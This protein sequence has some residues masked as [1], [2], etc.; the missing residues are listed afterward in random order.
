MLYARGRR[1]SPLVMTCIART[2]LVSEPTMLSD[3]D[4]L[5]KAPGL[6]HYSGLRAIPLGATVVSMHVLTQPTLPSSASA[7]D[8]QAC[9]TTLR[10]VLRQLRKQGPQPI[11]GLNR[12]NCLC[13][14]MLRRNGI[15]AKA[16]QSDSDVHAA[17]SQV[18]PALPALDGK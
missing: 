10:P 17:Q 18:L 7:I 15:A 5:R 11:F 9:P 16:A 3:A 4:P 8:C 12:C 1:P 6:M 14:R 13:A 2:R